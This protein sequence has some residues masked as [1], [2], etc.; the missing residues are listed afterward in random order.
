[1][2][3]SEHILGAAIFD[4]TGLPKDY[5]ISTEIA[6]ISWVQTIFQVLGLQTLLS[7]AFQL[8]DF[9]YAVVH[10]A[11]FHAL[12]IGKPSCYVALLIRQS[13]MVMSEALVG[14]AID[15]DPAVLAQDPRFTA[16]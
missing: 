12:I 16:T 15:F 8:D 9:R 5:Y 10:G 11:H 6:D 14:W 7:S 3:Y 2:S 13:E 4:L 1:V